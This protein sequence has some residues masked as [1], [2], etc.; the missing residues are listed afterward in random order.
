MRMKANLLQSLFLKFSPEWT[1]RKLFMRWYL[2]T[3]K[4]FLKGNG[5]EIRIEKEL[6][7]PDDV[8][9]KI[10]KY[11]KRRHRRRAPIVSVTRLKHFCS[12]IG[13]LLNNRPFKHLYYSFNKIANYDEHQKSKLKSLF[14]RLSFSTNAKLKYFFRALKE[15]TT[16]QQETIQK[17]MNLRILVEK[18]MSVLVSKAGNNVK[19]ALGNQKR[20]QMQ[21]VTGLFL[22]K[23]LL[24]K[25]RAFYGLLRHSREYGKHEDQITMRLRLFFMNIMDAQ[26]KKQSQALNKL[27]RWRKRYHKLIIP[28]KM[29]QRLV[30][31]SASYSLRSGFDSIKLAS[32]DGK[33]LKNVAVQNL[34][35]SQVSKLKSAFQRLKENNLYSNQ[36]K[37]MSF[38]ELK[39]KKMI[40]RKLID[41]QK[42][43]LYRS[44]T[45]LQEH[46]RFYQS[47]SEII[48]L[49][50]QFLIEKIFLKNEQ[51]IQKSFSK[52]TQHSFYY[53]RIDTN[54]LRFERTLMKRFKNSMYSSFTEI[55]KT[56]QKHKE[57]Y[58]LSSAINKLFLK[59]LRE[60]FT[61]IYESSEERRLRN[62]R[63]GLIKL[64][65]IMHSRYCKYRLHF[66][67]VVFTRVELNPWFRRSILK[68]TVDGPLCEQ[69]TFWKIRELV[70]VER[71]SKKD[72]IKR[73]KLIMKF[74]G[75][76]NN[77]RLRQLAR[78]FVK[79]STMMTLLGSS[80]HFMM[81][82]GLSEN[83]SLRIGTKS[84]GGTFGTSNLEF[85]RN[86][87][88]NNR[89]GGYQSVTGVGNS[90]SEI[91]DDDVMKVRFRDDSI[92]KLGSPNPLMLQT[93]MSGGFSMK[94]GG[95][96]DIKE[97]S[98]QM[99][100]GYSRSGQGYASR[101]A[102]RGKKY[103]YERRSKPYYDTFSRFVKKG[104][105]GK[106]R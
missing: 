41:S 83:G 84:S 54:I 104:V 87:S 85:G 89:Y 58:A 42:S 105:T 16:K 56:S 98:S 18:S 3:N 45:T 66:K 67:N 88:I 70:A 4:E 46:S 102:S 22:D 103:R 101:D 97:E 91:L 40:I 61:S 43:K 15:V 57:G 53:S 75:I 71:N 95:T 74:N 33:N 76:F 69:T 79:I 34:C 86:R 24:T 68:L 52:L 19:E 48:S 31:K 23:V 8:K 82:P 65:R 9:Y 80:Q 13:R 90:R 64:G 12:I 62:I 96:E 47:R 29:L 14:E 35:Y 38:F 6:S 27:D 78:T 21:R 99:T 49:K 39:L 26:R 106:N 51:K 60:G 30:D 81:S 25:N 94:L 11:K 36:R 44:I 37:M 50:R 5:K 10:S 28:I 7:D 73:K 32:W 77:L 72:Y 63:E 17:N 59:Q 2:L 92:G 20:D 100:E 55:F 1:K 93:S